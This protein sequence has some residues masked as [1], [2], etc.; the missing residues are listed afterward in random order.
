MAAKDNGEYSINI[1]KKR[2]T[3]ATRRRKAN[4]SVSDEDIFLLY[5][6]N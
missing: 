3:E 2:K 1:W 4:A 5:N 6:N